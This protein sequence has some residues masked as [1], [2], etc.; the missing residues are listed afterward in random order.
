[1]ALE[2]NKKI[3]EMY[4]MRSNIRLL[5]NNN[6][7]TQYEIN[8]LSRLNDSFKDAILEATI[9]YKGLSIQILLNP[10]VS[11][12]DR[13][14]II[15]TINNHIS[16]FI[17]DRSSDRDIINYVNNNGQVIDSFY[18]GNCIKCIL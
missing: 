6:N 18:V 4:N 16:T 10:D 1:M 3:D 17:L 12:K 14:G 5:Y 11:A 9:D 13:E 7:T 8:L 15:R 2:D